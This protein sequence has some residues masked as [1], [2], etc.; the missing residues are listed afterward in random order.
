LSAHSVVAGE[1]C[2]S[3]MLVH[4]AMLMSILSML[5]CPVH[6]LPEGKTSGAVQLPQEVHLSLQMLSSESAF[7]IDNGIAF[8][9]RLGRALPAHFL[10]QLFGV[11]SLDAVDMRKVQCVHVCIGY[12]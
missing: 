6:S 8:Y 12:L 9:M 7:L 4:V 3:F 1:S 5:L 2:V 11:Q 10:F